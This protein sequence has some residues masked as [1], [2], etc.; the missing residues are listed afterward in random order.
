MSK[1]EQLSGGEVAYLQVDGVN[2][3]VCVEQFK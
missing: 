3:C 1:A 2:H